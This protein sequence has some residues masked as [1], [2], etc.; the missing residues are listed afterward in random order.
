MD[1]LTTEETA[2][3]LHIP[4]ATLRHWIATDQ[5]PRSARIGRRRMFRRADCIDF[6]NKKFA[7][8]DTA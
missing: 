5:A 3:F 7:E 4:L 6:V 1:L 2:Q 8:A